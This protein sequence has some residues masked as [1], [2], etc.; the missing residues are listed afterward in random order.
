[1]ESQPASYLVGRFCGSHGEEHTMAT[2]ILSPILSP[3]KSALDHSID[4]APLPMDRPDGPEIAPVH[5]GEHLKS[6]SNSLR[7]NDG[8][9]ADPHFVRIGAVAYLNTKPLIYSL[10]DRLTRGA[11]AATDSSKDSP[12]GSLRLELPSRLATELENESLDVGLIPVVEYF[13]NLDRYL[14][15]SDAAIACRGPVWSVRILFRKAPCEVRTLAVDEGSRTSIALS[16][17]LFHSRFQFVPETTP[18]PMGMAPQSVDA[19][20]VLVIGDRAMKPE[21]FREDFGTD[22][23][24]GEEWLRET[25]LPFVFARWVARNRS[26]ATPGL[27]AVLEQSRD[28]GC[29]NI[30]EIVRLQ[31]GRYGLSDEECRDYLTRFLRFRLGPDER[32]G[33]AEFHRRC[34]ALRLVPEGVLH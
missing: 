5:G 19:D 27:A 18:L 24:L 4:A 34:Q 31:A 2:D 21:R 25:G 22:W 28:A 8:E 20:A 13:Q 32:A 17:I 29:A 30:D 7:V 16:K 1:M 26:F 15:V 6:S 10:L 33:L 3:R 23:D 11:D 9:A 14:G 12:E